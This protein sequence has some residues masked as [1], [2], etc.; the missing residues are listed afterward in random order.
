MNNRE[1]MIICVTVL[2]CV[3]IVCSTVVY[4]SHDDNI[5]NNTAGNVSVN[6]TTNTSNST[7]NTSSGSTGS[8]SSGSTGSADSSSSDNDLVDGEYRTSDG[9]IEGTYHGQDYALNGKYPYY[10]EQYGK[11]FHSAKEERQQFQHEI[12]DP[13]YL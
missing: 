7:N 1:L 3:V 8:S 9:M 10:S 12:D 5:R 2:V 13:N 6:N 4:I 11:T